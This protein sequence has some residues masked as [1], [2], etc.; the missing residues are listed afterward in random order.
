[1]SQ[2]LIN[3]EEQAIP[4]IAA[5][6]EKELRRARQ[7]R[8]VRFL[9][10]VFGFG[11]FTAFLFLAYLRVFELPSFQELENPKSSVASEVFAGDGSSLG[12]YFL[13]NRVPVRYD[14]LPRHL[15]DALICTED[16]RFQEHS[17]IDAEALGRVAKGIVNGTDAGGGSTISQQ[18][19]KLLFDRPSTKGMN[20]LS[21]A[22]SMVKIKF[23]EWIVAVQLERNYTKEEIMT[24][25]LNK[26]NFIN[27][28][29]GVKTACEVYFGKIPQELKIE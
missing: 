8:G 24:M 23:K 15:I 7:R 27:G 17:G 20:P 9:W 13:E 2:E 18:L 19:A 4:A 22:F 11:M 1:M 26:F 21:K 5:P 3:N 14:Q 12:R 10:R 29:Y 16:E 6:T 25:Y 28:A